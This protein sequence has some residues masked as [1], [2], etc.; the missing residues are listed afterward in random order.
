MTIWDM[1]KSNTFTHNHN[2]LMGTTTFKVHPI[3]PRSPKNT[4]AT[5]FK[6]ILILFAFDFLCIFFFL[7]MYSWILSTILLAL[8]RAKFAC[9]LAISNPVFRWESC[10]GSKWESVK[11]CSRL[12]KDTETHGWIRGWL[13]TGS[14]QSWHTCRVC[15][16]AEESCQLLHYRTKVLG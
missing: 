16:G 3:T 12:Y 15:G 7:S 1:R 6:S 9:I 2:Y 4:L 11:K 5:I 14:L 8:F 10:K 13:A